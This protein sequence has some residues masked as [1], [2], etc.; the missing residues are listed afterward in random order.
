MASTKITLS[1]AAK[2]AAADAVIGCL[3]NGTAY[4]FPLLRLKDYAGATLLDF[5][6]NLSPVFGA[7]SGG[8]GSSPAT[9]TLNGSYSETYSIV[10]PHEAKTFE[11]L[12][13]DRNVVVSGSVEKWS[14]SGAHPSCA[15]EAWPDD[16]LENGD[17]VTFS[18]WSLWVNP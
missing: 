6:L 3:S 11:L 12:D 10:A 13:K 14:G 5:E 18:N 4:G 7:A 2:K 17:T 8:V 9:A 15:L 16:V 1:E